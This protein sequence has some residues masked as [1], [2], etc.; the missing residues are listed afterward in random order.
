[1]YPG[2]LLLLFLLIFSVGD[3]ENGSGDIYAF[4]VDKLLQFESH[5]S[6]KT[7]RMAVHFFNCNMRVGGRDRQ[8]YK[9]PNILANIERVSD[10]VKCHVSRQ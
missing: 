6:L 3:E 4:S 8:M 7:Q 2:S 9:Q 1:M 5:H 10:L